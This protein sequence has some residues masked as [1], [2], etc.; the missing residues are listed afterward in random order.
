M[1]KSTRLIKSFYK[2]FLPVV[3]LFVVAAGAASIWFAHES[4]KPS[5]AAYLVTPE[6]YGQLSARGAQVTEETWVNRD[7]TPARGWLLRGAENA[8]AVIL[9]HKYGADRSHVLNLGVKLNEA[10]N[11]TVLMP[12]LRGHGLNPPVDYTSFGGCEAM[13]TVAAIEF[14]RGQKTASL[15]PLV[16][17]EIGL[18]GLEMGSLAALNAGAQDQSVKAMVLDSVPSD[19]DSLVASVIDSRFPFVSSVTSRLGQLGAYPYFYEGCYSRVPVCDLAQ[20]VGGRKAMLLGGSDAPQFQE[21]TNKLGKCFP[22]TTKTEV[23]TSL[24]PSGF[25][26]INSSIQVSEAYDQ[27]VIDF[28][29]VSLGEPMIIASDNTK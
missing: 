3:L 5:A 26:V 2:L 20:Q 21:S 6:K 13:D 25:S 17:S 11:F 10:S 19:S 27:R 15:A 1:A 8:P 29:R 7:G 16:G 14:L 23:N 4:S 12:D 9:L 24:S 18:Y 22:S 28:F